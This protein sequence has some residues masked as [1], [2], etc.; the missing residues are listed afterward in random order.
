MD[1]RKNS[2]EALGHG[3]PISGFDTEG[4]N[5]PIRESKK[6]IQMKFDSSAFDKPWKIAIEEHFAIEDTLGDSAAYASGKKDAWQ[7]LSSNLGDFTKQRIEQMDQTGVDVSILSLNS[8]AIQGVYDK[9]RAVQVARKSNDVLANGIAK[10]SDRF[11][12]FAA[13]PTQ[14]PD[15]AIKELGRCVKELGFVGAL[16]NGFSQIGEEDTSYNL[17][18][19]KYR[20]FWAE[21]EK[22]GVPVYLHP[23][24]PLA[25]QQ[26][27]YEGHPWLLGAAWAFGVETATHALRLIGSGLFDEY[28]KLKI[29]IGHLGEG[30][31]FSIWRFEHRNLIDPRGMNLNKKASL[32]FY[33]NFYVTTSGNYRTQALINTILEMGSDHILYA[34]DYPFESMVETEE[35]FRAIDISLEDQIKIGRLNAMKLFGLE[36]KMPKGA[37]A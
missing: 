29:L 34:T 1:F 35:W 19:P 25:S 9:G 10:H 31:P 17:D 3:G 22:L 23:R 8:P 20:P 26:R 18:I 24:E 7:K 4:R 28:P 6:E 30:L 36:T 32:Y 37:A 15:G 12:A 13:L 2:F 33:E 11:R 14:D 21:V 27:V 5:S 16:I